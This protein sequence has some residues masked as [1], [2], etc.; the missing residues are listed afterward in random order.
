MYLDFSVTRRD[1]CLVDSTKGFKMIEVVYFIQ[2]QN[3]SIPTFGFL[4][5]NTKHH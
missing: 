4:I 2:F 5:I 1:T 3:L